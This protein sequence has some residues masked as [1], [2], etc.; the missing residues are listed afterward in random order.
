MIDATPGAAENAN[1]DMNEMAFALG[2]LNGDG[3]PDVVAAS[4]GEGP[5]AMD[6]PRQV[7]DGLVWYESP[8]DPRRDVWLKHVIAP[9]VG[10]VHAS[11]IQLADFDGDGH[12]DIC[13]AE[14]DQSSRRKDGQ[15][16]RQLGL[17]YNV[18]GDA[19]TW[20]LQILS[21]YPAAGAGGFN[22]KV[23]LIGSDR[24]PSIFT[25]LHGYFGD[26]NPLILWRNQGMAGNQDSS[27]SQR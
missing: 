13:Y 9:G 15:P 8:R 12:L 21:Q 11:S 7:G 17:Y 20:K 22:S 19:K 2:D 25:S 18:R 3:R 26:A 5:D 10:W 1:R 6:D 4:M 27:R 14:Q 24:L 16:S 23:G